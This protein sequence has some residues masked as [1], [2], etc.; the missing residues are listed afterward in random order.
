MARGAHGASGRTIVMLALPDRY[1]CRRVRGPSVLGAA[2]SRKGRSGYAGGLATR[3][4]GGA[5]EGEMRGMLRWAGS[6]GWAKAKCPPPW[7]LAIPPPRLRTRERAGSEQGAGEAVRLAEQGW[8]CPPPWPLAI[9]PPRLRTRERDVSEQ[10]SGEA[11]R[12]AEQG[13]SAPLPGRWPSLPRGKST[14]GR[15][16]AQR[17][18]GGTGRLAGWLARSIA[19]ARVGGR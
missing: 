7:P 4:R 1:S 17:H 19:W 9:P 13:V 6:S 12:L 5:R 8:K 3:R 16:L 10:G 11:V 15:D 18:A 2:Q 14:R